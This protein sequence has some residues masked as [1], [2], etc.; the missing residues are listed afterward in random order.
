M[1][2]FSL[3]NKSDAPC[4][5]ALGFFDGV[6]LG[7]RAVLKKATE[8]AKARG[9]LSAVF[10][11]TDNKKEGKKSRLGKIYSAQR[12]CELI[13][14]LGLDFAIMPDFS[15]FSSLS[16]EQF[17]EILKNNFKACAFVCGKDF[18]FGKGAVGDTAL[19]KELAAQCG[20]ETYVV[21]DVVLDG[22]N[23]SSTR[24]RKALSDGDIKTANKLL[25]RQYSIRSEVAHGKNIG[26]KVLYPTINQPF[27]DGDAILKFGVYASKTIYDGKEMPSVTNIGVCP[28]FLDERKPVSETYIIDADVNLY[29]KR[30]EVRLIDFLRE[31]K[32]FESPEALK[33]QIEK[34]IEA[35]KNLK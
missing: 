24:I 9:V 30:V 5:I 4:V 13:S 28:T 1:N 8:Q 11:F 32:R 12:R 22:E 27:E 7:H 17:V 3:E 35:A 33:I 25:G 20:I 6:H 23:V 31:E 18:R 10:S 19:L 16:P 15:A 26:S 21:E 29:G 2:I 14:E 34:D